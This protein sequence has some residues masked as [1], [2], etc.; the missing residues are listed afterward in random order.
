MLPCLIKLGFW[1]LDRADE[2]RVVQTVF[3]LRQAEQPAPIESLNNLE[4]AALKS[5]RVSLKGRFSNS[6]HILLDNK[7]HHAR[8]GYEVVSPFTLSANGQTVLVNRGWIQGNTDRRIFPSITPVEGEQSINGVIYI[9]SKTPFSVGT[10]E[11]TDSWPK[12]V[13]FII[14]EDFQTYFGTS[15]YPYQI[16]IDENQAG[17]LQR[18]WL[19]ISVK[20]EKHTG[21]AVQWFAMAFTL[22]LLYLIFS[23][24]IFDRFR[25]KQVK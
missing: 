23:T 12:R 5:V 8:F 25:S 24:N 3:K 9:P 11:L 6:K 4:S 22:A 20:P 1:Q 14:Q 16:H 15:L 13:P 19:T 18:N 21:Y 17:T 10:T 2:K 7:I